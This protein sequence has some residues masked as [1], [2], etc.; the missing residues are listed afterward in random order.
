MTI[1]STLGLA[2][3]LAEVLRNRN[4]LD[5]SIFLCF[6]LVVAAIA[7]SGFKRHHGKPEIWVALGITAVYGTVI[8]RMGIGPEERTHLF[9][10]GLVAVLIHQALWLNGSITF[11]GFHFRPY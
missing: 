11:H 9:E 8:L 4:L 10:Y 7:G 1:Y 5:N 3:M 6:L 2:G